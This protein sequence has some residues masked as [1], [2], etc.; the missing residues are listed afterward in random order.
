MYITD[1]HGFKIIVR[2]IQVSVVDRFQYF[3]D[4]INLQI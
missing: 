1:S 2:Y 4:K 3:K